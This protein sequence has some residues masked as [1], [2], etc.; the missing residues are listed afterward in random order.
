[1][2]SMFFGALRDWREEEL[3][4]ASSASPQAEL[5]TLMAECEDLEVGSWSNHCNKALK[6]KYD[7]TRFNIY[8]YIYTVYVYIVLHVYDYI[9]ICIYI[10]FIVF[11]NIYMIIYNIQYFDSI[12]D[13]TH[14]L[15]YIS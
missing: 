12:Y 6:K 15:Y 1:M 3:P 8:M 9:Y 2:F 4:R 14:T 10:S 11:M 5:S 7:S 13:Y